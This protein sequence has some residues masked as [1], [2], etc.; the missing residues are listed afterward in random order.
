[1]IF[2]YILKRLNL[3]VFLNQILVH[4]MS[5]NLYPKYITYDKCKS[6]IGP[7]GNDYSNNSLRNHNH[8]KVHCYDLGR[9][10]RPIL[11]EYSNYW[12]GY[13]GYRDIRWVHI[14]IDRTMA[15]VKKIGN[16]R[17]CQRN[18]LFGCSSNYIFH[19]LD[20]P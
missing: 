7:V 17:Q 5:W 8:S 16:S 13:R 4:S 3:K 12:R 6:N 20:K 2:L 18:I 1:M 15:T 14:E 10:H 11:G 9:Y 19:L